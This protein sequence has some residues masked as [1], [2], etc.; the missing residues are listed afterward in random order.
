MQSATQVISR[1]R[2][3]GKAHCKTKRKKLQNAV[4]QYRHLCWTTI[5]RLLEHET[6]AAAVKGSAFKLVRAEFGQVYA[7]LFSLTLDHQVSCPRNRRHGT[8]SGT[9][10]SLD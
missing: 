9:Q 6:V 4:A 7:G 5:L 10:V 1:R 3:A 8:S 2:P